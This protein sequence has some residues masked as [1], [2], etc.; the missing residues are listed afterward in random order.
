MNRAKAMAD[1]WEWLKN[2]VWNICEGF[3]EELSTT[4]FLQKMLED[5]KNLLIEQIDFHS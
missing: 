3:D 2:E 5:H 1:L 4:M